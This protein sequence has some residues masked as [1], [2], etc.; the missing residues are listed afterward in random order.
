[1]HL[2]PQ[3]PDS[4]PAATCAFTLTPAGAPAPAVRQE[5]ESISPMV[6]ED[7]AKAIRFRREC[8][9][10]AALGH[11]AAVL[12]MLQVMAHPQQLG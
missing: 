4:I 8:L 9:P 12:S 3:V 6:A 2:H 1:V 7:F 11:S 5:Q 10:K